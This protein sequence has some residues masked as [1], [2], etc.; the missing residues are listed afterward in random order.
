ME[1]GIGLKSRRVG[2]CDTS[3]QEVKSDTWEKRGA[4]A[5]TGSTLLGYIIENSF[6]Y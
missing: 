1:H 2:H 5:E 3:N 6:I 4:S